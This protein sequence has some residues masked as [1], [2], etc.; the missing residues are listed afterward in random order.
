MLGPP[1]LHRPEPWVLLDFPGPLPTGQTS[2]PGP[3]VT[4]MLTAT[5]PSTRPQRLWYLLIYVMATVISV[6]TRDHPNSLST[7]GT[8]SIPRRPG[9]WS[10][11]D[12]QL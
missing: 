12:M 4:G 5:S 7:K 11:R 3:P 2:Q 1:S 6:H 8:H 10:S 9:L